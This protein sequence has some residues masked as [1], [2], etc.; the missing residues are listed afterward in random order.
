MRA[1]RAASSAS[2]ANASSGRSIDEYDVV[3]AVVG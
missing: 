1:L 2:V 3:H